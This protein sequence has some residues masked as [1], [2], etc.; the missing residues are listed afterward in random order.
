[1]HFNMDKAVFV[2]FQ[3][4]HDKTILMTGSVIW[5]KALNL[6][7]VLGYDNFQAGVG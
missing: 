7:N 6:A 1:M 4:I 3:E 2:W 5:K